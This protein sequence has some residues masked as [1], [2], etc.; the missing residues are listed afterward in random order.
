M[1]DQSRREQ[2]QRPAN[3]TTLCN[4]LSATPIHTVTVVFD[5]SGDSGKFESVETGRP[6]GGLSVWASVLPGP[7]PESI[8]LGPGARE[9][10]GR[11]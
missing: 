1:R 10:P 5:G 8:A 11:N 4:A 3:K 7:D 6:R 2:E 9:G